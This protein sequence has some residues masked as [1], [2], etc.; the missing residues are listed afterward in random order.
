MSAEREFPCGAETG[1]ARPWEGYGFFRRDG[2]IFQPPD[3][4]YADLAAWSCYPKSER[5]RAW[6]PK[7]LHRIA[8]KSA[9]YWGIDAERRLSADPAS[10]ERLRVEYVA[11]LVELRAESERLTRADREVFIEQAIPLKYRQ[12]L[13]RSGATITG[14]RK[15]NW[16]AFDKV[17]RWIPGGT[18]PG[19]VCVGDTGRGKTLAV[20]HRCAAL[21]RETGVR[22]LALTA[23]EVKRRL[24]EAARSDLWAEGEGAAQGIEAEMLAAPIVF[25]DDLSQAKL[26]AHYAE[27]LFAIVEHRTAHGLPLIVT[28][29][30]GKGALIRK[31]AGY[32]DAFLDTAACLARRLED[33]C[34][35]VNF[36]TTAQA[37]GRRK[38]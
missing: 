10:V 24:I 31:L 4:T 30:M 37:S 18:Q 21:H 8:G 32:E 33:Y 34:Q 25:I 38:Q 19:L 16:T 36:G 11:K 23:D 2:V 7:G 20:F 12:P 26:T 28:V 1:P 3:T 17:Q 13:D 35:P 9:L 15:V 5:F 29:Q 22:F 6:W 14:A 27:R